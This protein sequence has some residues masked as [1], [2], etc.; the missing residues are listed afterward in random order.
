M[1]QKIKTSW[2]SARLSC[3]CVWPLNKLQS[4]MCPL[5]QIPSKDNKE[6]PKLQPKGLKADTQTHTLSLTS[7][8]ES[9]TCAISSADFISKSTREKRWTVAGK[10][11]KK[12]FP[13][14]V[15]Q[16]QIH[17]AGFGAAPRRHGKLRGPWIGGSVTADVLEERTDIPVTFQ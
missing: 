1:N 14:C 12:L 9:G 15:F 16:C 6:P 13:P 2:D 4:Q 3:V 7:C 10:T 8:C 5:W 11:I 17:H